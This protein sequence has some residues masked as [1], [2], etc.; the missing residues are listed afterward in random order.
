MKGKGIMKKI[1]A[2]LFSLMLICSFTF[3]AFALQQG[4]YGEDVY[5][6]QT[7]LIEQG[8]LEGE[9]D[10]D[11]GLMTEATVKAYQEA[12]GLEATGILSDADIAFIYGTDLLEETDIQWLTALGYLAEGEASPAS[13]ATAL[14]NFKS[15]FGYPA[16][17]P[18]EEFLEALRM[19][20]AGVAQE[21]QE[22]A[23][24]LTM[25][26]SINILRYPDGT[27]YVEPN[28]VSS[29][30]FESAGAAFK[31]ILASLAESTTAPAGDYRCL[32]K[33]NADVLPEHVFANELVT[34]EDTPYLDAKLI[35]KLVSRYGKD[36]ALETPEGT[37]TFRADG[38][39]EGAPVY[40]IADYDYDILMPEASVEGNPFH[41]YDR[42]T[43]DT[44]RNLLLEQTDEGYYVAPDTVTARTLDEAR[45]AY[46][47][48][49]YAYFHSTDIPNRDLT[50]S[51]NVDTSS[52]PENVTEDDLEEADGAWYLRFRD[53]QDIAERSGE[54]VTVTDI[55]GS[56]V[57]ID[58]LGTIETEAEELATLVTD[59]DTQEVISQGTEPEPV[60][61]VTEPETTAFT[62]VTVPEPQEPV[63]VWEP[64]A[65][66][67]PET[68]EQAQPQ[69]EPQ[70]QPQTPEPTKPSVQ[71]PQTPEPTQPSVPEPE[72]T[73][74]HQ[75]SWNPVYRTVHHD[76]VT[77]VVHHDAVTHTVHHD[78]VTHVVHH[79]AVYDTKTIEEP[80]YEDMPIYET[81]YYKYC[82]GC[83]RKWYDM[84]AFA[85]EFADHSIDWETGEVLC[86]G[87]E[88]GDYDYNIVGYE[89]VQTGTTTRTEQVL[90]SDAYDDTVTDSPAY[91]ETVTDSP[92]YDETVTDSPAYDEQVLDHYECSVCGAVK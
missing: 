46:A 3:S 16:S 20:T 80:V 42:D 45:R 71:E 91:D 82:T 92:A 69:T 32:I 62:P 9:A 85:R 56:G 44:F 35:G 84:D 25:F 23:R 65:T 21:P 81:V 79:D 27:W 61:T 74:A 10:G 47:T 13:L 89:S 68:P 1:V 70:T 39:I 26:R 6:L 55:Y 4:D 51:L 36:L 5:A 48:V 15:D 37:I 86:W 12:N 41:V 76:A 49:R 88:A 11:Y 58:G 77:H 57:T 73:T 64:E 40:V 14:T 24:E 54:P 33:I 22:S 18:K 52:L 59:T 66:P 8:Y 34:I 72:T 28:T 63:T 90:V 7:F 83:G 87:N 29:Q 19:V 67:E 31:A 78:A 43:T 30:T 2:L 50:A 60:T 17:M 53:A 38:S 75:H